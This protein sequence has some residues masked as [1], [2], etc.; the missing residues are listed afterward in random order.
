MKPPAQI[1]Y[2]R[3]LLALAG[4][5]LCAALAS[6]HWIVPLDRMVYDFFN[7]SNPM[8]IADDI[9]IVAID[10]NSLR[11]LGRWPWP[12]EKHVELL[13]QLKLAGAAA[14]GLDILFTEAEADYPEVDVLLAEAVSAHGAVVLPVFIAHDIRGNQL[15][16]VLPIDVLREAAAGLGHVHIEVDGDGVA[17]RVFLREGIG[18]PRWPHFS[19]AIDRLL[20]QGPVDLP[21]DANPRSTSVYDSAT[22][23]RNYENLIPF[24]G[25]AGSVPTLSYVDVIKGRVPLHYLRD[26][27]VLVGATTAGYVDNIATS[28]G[29]ISGVEINANILHALRTGQFVRPVSA[30]IAGLV[31]FLLAASGIMLFTRTAPRQLILG[32]L[33]GLVVLPL[34]SFLLFFFWRI[35][36]SPAPI[37]VTLII[38]FPLWNWL[39]LDAAVG[40]IGRQLQKLEQENR[41]LEPARGWSDIERTATFL[42]S[43]GHVR[44]WH[45]GPGDA[46]GA[47]AD[48]DRH[49]HFANHSSRKCFCVDGRIRRLTLHWNP[50]SEFVVPR[51]PLLFRESG[52]AGVRARSGADFVDLNL[53]ALEHAYTRARRNHNLI[54]ATLEQLESAVILAELSGEVVLV[55]DQAKVL[56]NIKTPCRE[57]MP[58]LRSITLAR[59]QNIADLINALIFRGVHFESE[60]VATA[61]RRDI[62]CHGALINPDHPMLLVVVVDVSELK[63]SEKL[64]AEAL[65]FLSHD[66]RA[67]L[68]SVLA[69]IE[70]VTAGK[71]GAHDT[72]PLEQIEKYIEQTLSYADHFLHMAKLEHAGATRMEDTDASSLIDNAVAQLFHTSKKKGVDV[73]IAYGDATVWLRCDRSLMERALLNLIDNALKH[74]REGSRVTVE[75]DRDPDCAIFHV[76]DQGEGIAASDMER[77]FDDF[78]Q[79]TGSSGGVGLGL[80]FVFAVSKSHGGSISVKNNVPAGVCFTL[81]VPRLPDDTANV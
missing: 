66:L 64:R 2:F 70:S 67:P 62:L 47:A 60:G 39:R 58:T 77:I 23:V 61:S 1:F 69:L 37:V 21:G 42:E 63:K 68:T 74:S 25:R 29:Q 55:N 50:E 19:A 26:K 38:A 65:N 48:D 33:G 52:E 72:V 24:M 18:Q 32:V 36:L 6:L 56:L 40:F 13:R 46:P 35:W 31:M 54:R 9:V 7:E 43:L 80:R 44:S 79:G 41:Q 49:W 8:P 71:T 45:W 34:G 30:G 78:E 76:S 5:L 53:R 10:E 22:M 11:E 4:G 15:Q 12:R 28:L 75:L 51:L 73:R 57:L 16:E 3:L 20:T 27:V 17:R 81:K 59:Q 14:V